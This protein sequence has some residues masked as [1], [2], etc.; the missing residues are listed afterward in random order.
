M[1][2]PKIKIVY[3]TSSSFKEKENEVFVRTCSLA[4]GRRVADLFEFE[5]M[6]VPIQEILDVNLEAMVR[7]EV[8]SAY[9]QLKVPCIV[10][11]A[12]LVFDDYAGKSYPG[13]LTKPMWD[14]LKDQFIEETRSAGRAATARAVIAYC[15]G[16]RILTF[17]GERKGRIAEQVRGS[18]K[19]YWDTIFMPDD[20]MG[21]AIGR[22]YA[23]I[24]DDPHLGL[25]YKIE[26]L[27]QSSMAMK[28]FLEFRLLNDEAE[29][30][31]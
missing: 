19:F 7:A 25:D 12:G 5:I 29:I 3:V 30:W 31:R 17:I 8:L 4:D 13:G 10:E 27:S 18:R 28:A 14:T 11:H 9:T 2:I 24:V 22:T 21:N 15:D 16:M 23:E 20:P 1:M 26:H 6:K